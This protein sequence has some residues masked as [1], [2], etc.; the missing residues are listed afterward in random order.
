MTLPHFEDH[1]SL[2]AEMIAQLDDF[3]RIL[4]A[5]GYGNPITG[6]KLAAL[7]GWQGHNGKNGDA[8]VRG[9]VAY[10][11]VEQHL[12]IGS[13]GN[14]YFWAVKAQEL[15]GTLEHLRA[16]VSRIAAV[17]HGVSAARDNLMVEQGRLFAPSV[18]REGAH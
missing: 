17:V 13:E 18:G 4:R 16:R 5:H 10:L 7:M 3:V 12:P 14:G 9:A 11:R 8:R 1:T 2:S 15:D 6:G